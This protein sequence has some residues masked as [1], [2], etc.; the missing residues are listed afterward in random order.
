MEAIPLMTMPRSNLLSQSWN[1][2]TESSEHTL[3]LIL[4]KESDAFHIEAW[5]KV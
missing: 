3:K 2:R 5:W 1:G 4:V